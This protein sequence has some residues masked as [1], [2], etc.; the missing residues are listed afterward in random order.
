MKKEVFLPL[1]AAAVVAFA[2]QA[3]AVD[4][5]KLIQSGAGKP[6]AVEV[7]EMA[8]KHTPTASQK[9]EDHDIAQ[10]LIQRQRQETHGRGHT[11]S[12][13]DDIDSGKVNV[14]SD[15]D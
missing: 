12:G 6:G 13:D 9:Q 2:G 7:I 1:L 3:Y 8:T 11:L 10:G 14:D 15:N 4:Q 5:N